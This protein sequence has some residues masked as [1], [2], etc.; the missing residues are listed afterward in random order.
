MKNFILLSIT[1]MLS[2][3]GSSGGNNDTRSDDNGSPSEPACKSVYSQWQ[4][5][6]DFEEFDFTGFENGNLNPDYSYQASDGA[7]C[8]YAT[9]PNH[10]LAADLI[11]SS[12][13]LATYDYILRMS[14]TLRMT[15]ACEFYY[16]NGS[17]GGGHYNTFI[18][19]TACNQVT[20]CDDS[21][22]CKTFH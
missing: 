11:E 1:L 20:I 19:E 9:N 8:G 6:T 21:N 18:S 17:T 22:H 5:D 14:A 12:S 4:S 15:G 7:T 10:E 16:Q 13:P 3:C 2:A